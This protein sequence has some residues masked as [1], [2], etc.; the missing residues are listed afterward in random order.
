[1]A[2]RRYDDYEALLEA[3][4]K[5]DELRWQE[6]A[7]QIRQHSDLSGKYPMSPELQ[8]MQMSGYARPIGGGGGG[9]GGMSWLDKGVTPRPMLT[10]EQREA[11]SRVYEGMGKDKPADGR[12]SAEEDERK[13]LEAMLKMLYAIPTLTPQQ[14]K[15]RIETE[16]R[17]S[18]L[19]G[20]PIPEG[21]AGSLPKKKSA[22]ERFKGLFTSDDDEVR[23]GLQGLE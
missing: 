11:Q 7:K 13:R 8:A 19:S 15:M 22:W 23:G 3:K 2:E 4:R 21:V 20:Q 1:M 14:E 9:G 10:P 12:G 18:A 16:R 17:W 5:D 6:I